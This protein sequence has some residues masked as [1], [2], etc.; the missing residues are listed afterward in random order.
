MKSLLTIILSIS[1]IASSFG[2]DLNDLWHHKDL[3]SDG[4]PGVS[5]KQAYD[6]LS[7]RPSKKVIV[8]IIDSGYELEH[9]AF[10]TNIWVNQDEIAGNGIDDDNNGY[11]DD[12]NGWNFLG[13]AN[14]NIIHENLEL[15]REYRKLKAKY[16]NASPSKSAE[17]KYWKEI[18]ERY[19]KES[20]ETFAAADGFFKT[21]NGIGYQYGLLAGYSQVDTLTVEALNSIESQDS[22]VMAADGYMTRILTYLGGKAT[23]SEVQVLFEGAKSYYDYQGNYAYNP[24]FDPR[25]IIGDNPTD[26]SNRSYGNNDI[27]E[28]SGYGGSHGTHVAG[29]VGGKS[30]ETTLGITEKVEFMFIRAIPSGD[31]RDKD[32]GNSIRYAVD[33]GAQVINMSF[34]KDYS[35]N[36]KYVREAVKYAEQKGVLMIHAAGN[37][38][39]NNDETL[40]FP[41]GSISSKKKSKNWIEVGA[42]SSSYDES[43]PAGFSNYGKENVDLF[44]PGVSILS[45]VPGNTY[46]AN[47]GT[48]MASPVVA[49]VSALLLSY[50]PDLTAAEVKEILMQSA[51]KVD[52]EVTIPGSEEKTNFSNLSRTGGIINAFEAVKLAD[53]R[54]KIKLR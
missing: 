5:L 16:E 33:N 19:L 34:G 43:L 38:G 35:P 3:E 29:I 27:G 18:E 50:F 24:E 15:T 10:Q 28:V 49:G 39:K 8:A 2:Q 32:V 9:D 7:D 46:E 37:D 53:K 31:E 45:A 54:V 13:G 52:L 11:I 51:T 20:E 41:D 25:D 22:I 44:A 17:Y 48:S 40:S 30:G 23:L 36:Q 42:S 47:S 26:F 14:G 4:V 6:Y 12:V 1:L 21:Y